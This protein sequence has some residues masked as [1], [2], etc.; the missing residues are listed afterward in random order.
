MGSVHYLH[1][2][3]VYAPGGDPLFPPQLLA[4]QGRP[5]QEENLPFLLAKL[6]QGDVADI[7]GY[8]IVAALADFHAQV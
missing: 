1:N 8:L 4:L 2:L 5:P 7:D 6:A 3:S